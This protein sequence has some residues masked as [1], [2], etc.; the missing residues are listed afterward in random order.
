MTPPANAWMDDVRLTLQRYRKL[1]GTKD[2]LANYLVR[3]IGDLE[4]PEMRERLDHLLASAVERLPVRGR[5]HRLDPPCF[6]ALPGCELARRLSAHAFKSSDTKPALLSFLAG[7]VPHSDAGQDVRALRLLDLELWSR[8]GGRIG[9]LARLRDVLP[10]RYSY[11]VTGRDPTGST[12]PPGDY[13]LKLIAYPTD[14]SA[15]T[16]RTVAFAIK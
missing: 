10:G 6:G 2:I 7:S 9:L 1:G 12:L 13:T 15:P 3:V 11:G 5:E 14:R 4:K 16:V 8:T